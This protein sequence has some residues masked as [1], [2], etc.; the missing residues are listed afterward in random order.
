MVVVDPFTVLY[1]L[2]VLVLILFRLRAPIWLSMVPPMRLTVIS[3]RLTVISDDPTIPTASKSA[4]RTSTC[5]VNMSCARICGTEITL[6]G[7]EMERQAYLRPV[8]RSNF[9]CSSGSSSLRCGHVDEGKTNATSM[10]FACKTNADFCVTHFC[11]PLT[12]VPS[13]FRS[14]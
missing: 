2:L 4:M 11:T 10:C 9:L 12:H 1:Q 5:G 6:N 8:L 7:V 14:L 3:M 13:H